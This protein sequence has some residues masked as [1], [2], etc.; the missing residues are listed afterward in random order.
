MIEHHGNELILKHAPKGGSVL[1]LGNQIMNLENVQDISAKEYYTSL[2]FAHT[3][4]DQ[5]GKDGAIAV[6]LSNPIDS[7]GQFDIITD[8]GTTEHVSDL[9]ECLCNVLKHC[10]EGT[11]IIHKNPKTGNFPG[12]GYHF[13]TLEFWAAYAQLC[14]LSI[15]EIYPHAI[16]HNI[17]DGYECIAILKYTSESIIPS[18]DD[19]ETIKNLVHA[20]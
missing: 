10:K 7:L 3:S 19:F 17:T 1:E 12:H 11:M 18:K 2:G 8:M 4:I 5:N 20:E 16:Y 14:K 15:I 9:Y 13:F 6:D